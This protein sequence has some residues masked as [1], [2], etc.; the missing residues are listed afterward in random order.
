MKP[1]HLAALPFSLA[2]CVQGDIER[3]VGAAWSPFRR[4]LLLAAIVAFGLAG[5]STPQERFAK[6]M[7]RG[8]N[9]DEASRAEA[10][11]CLLRGI[12]TAKDVP[13]GLKV[14]DAALPSRNPNAEKV[15]Y[16][17]V[18]VVLSQADLDDLPLALSR[19]H[20]AYGRH[21]VG[22]GGYETS[23]LRAG[24]M[25]YF[26]VRASIETVK[27][28]LERNEIATALAVR[29]AIRDVSLRNN[30]EAERQGVGGRF[31][32]TLPGSLLVHHEEVVLDRASGKP[33]PKFFSET[34]EE[35]DGLVETA[36]ER[37]ARRE[38]GFATDEIRTGRAVVVST[39]G[40]KAAA[41]ARN[42][43]PLE[44][45]EVK[46]VRASGTGVSVSDAR[47]DAI[48]KAVSRVAGEQVSS[49]TAIADDELVLDRIDSRTSGAV[50]GW[51]VIEGPVTADGLVRVVMD[52]RVRSRFLRNGETTGKQAKGLSFRKGALGDQV[53][54]HDR[55]QTI[56]D[57]AERES[58]AIPSRW[59]ELVLRRLAAE[60]DCAPDPTEELKVLENLLD[61]ELTKLVFCDVRTDRT[62]APVVNAGK[63]GAFSV[64]VN[65]GVSLERYNEW[66]RQLETAIAGLRR[67]EERPAA[68]AVLMVPSET[69]NSFGKKRAGALGEDA[70]RLFAAA[71]LSAKAV[72]ALFDASD[73]EL[74]RRE[75]PFD[76]VPPD[77]WNQGSRKAQWRWIV[78]REENVFYVAP[79]VFETSWFAGKPTCDIKPYP[80]GGSA[81]RDV[82][83][84]DLSP[85]AIRR[86]A[87]IRAW[88]ETVSDNGEEMDFK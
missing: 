20:N 10:A 27:A 34:M 3:V 58:L 66:E 5:C 13:R 17:W 67:P 31:E 82:V 9:G 80:Y 61:R 73:H 2:A 25:D 24:I 38:T 57:E 78:V 21:W 37:M 88:T 45:Q 59:S 72:V 14:L 18:Y 8:A 35:I 11:W 51:A 64:R 7:A 50:D 71:R 6:A 75:I 53:R 49:I 85:D 36:C 32:M 79:G 29:N 39:T 30:A 74:A 87:T 84:K 68:R 42:R 26:L 1:S 77:S 76:E 19:L 54:L 16:D 23:F 33:V 12:G 48:R 55:I 65:I 62:G 69:F 40:K 60:D 86:I 47:T 63:N 4:S 81:D 56:K 46:T 43:R 41:V 70:T 22:T 44:E 15:L 83:F 52:V 28:L